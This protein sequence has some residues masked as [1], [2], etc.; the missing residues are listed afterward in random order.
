ME[1]TLK[2]WAVV[3]TAFTST[4]SRPPKPSTGHS[5]HPWLDCTMALACKYFRS[6]RH[7][8]AKSQP[9]SPFT[10]RWQVLSMD[11][12]DVDAEEPAYFEFDSHGG[13]VFQ[14][15]SLQGVMDCRLS[16][17]GEEAAVDWAWE[18]GDEDKPA[19]GRGW[20]VLKGDELH[21][22]IVIHDADE[23]G[24]VAKRTKNNVHSEAAF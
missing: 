10:G 12:W 20:A 24:F 15:A 11:A 9:G 18:G 3:K 8:M 14:F 21:G 1:A 16:T 22:M 19:T 6:P 2:N 4:T 23:S 17:R 7:P 13:G 5:R